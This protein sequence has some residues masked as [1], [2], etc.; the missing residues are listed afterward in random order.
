MFIIHHENNHRKINIL[1]EIGI[2][3]AASFRYLLNDII[4][5]RSD[6]VYRLIPSVSDFNSNRQQPRLA[7]RRDILTTN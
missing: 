7:Y 3:K 6:P 2:L 4:N 1:E 5:G